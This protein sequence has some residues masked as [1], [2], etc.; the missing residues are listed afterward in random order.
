MGSSP[1]P[2]P[3]TARQP[4]RRRR[5][6]RR[7]VRGARAPAGGGDDAG[8]RTAPAPAARRRR[9]PAQPR[10]AAAAR[11]GRRR[12]ATSASATAR[13]P[14]CAG[15]SPRGTIDEASIDGAVEALRPPGLPR[16]RALRRA[17]SP[18]IAAR[19]TTGGPSA[20]SAGC[21]RSAWIA[22]LVAGALSTR[23]GAGELDAA[24]ALLRRRFREIPAT[25]RERER[26]LGMLARK[27]YDLELAYDA[28]RA[29]T[30]AERRVSASEAAASPEPGHWHA[31]RGAAWTRGP[32]DGRLQP[33]RRCAGRGVARRAV[34]QAP[35]RD[36]R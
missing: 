28:V 21:S 22:E 10:G 4:L 23:D 31:M 34:R 35:W 8:E 7:R 1:A 9:G 13:R 17:R 20:S 29:F 26:A 24:V 27:G 11:A 36:G 5:P 19:S 18:R 6:R 16:R 3:A 30:Q 12:T 2:R 33:R 15:T 14:R 25:D 32:A